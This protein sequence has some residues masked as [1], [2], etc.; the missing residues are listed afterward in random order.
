M[1]QP[2]YHVLNEYQKRKHRKYLLIVS[3]FILMFILAI[4]FTTLGT[5]DTTFSDVAG[6]IFRAFTS[7]GKIFDKQDKIIVLLRLPRMAMAII[8]GIGLSSAGAAMQAATRNPMVS[9]FTI[10]ISNAAAFGASLSI[11]FG[12]G[13]FSGSQLGTVFNAFL[14]ALGCMGL[15]ALISTKVGMSPSTIVL[16]GIA[17]N[18]LFSACTSTIEFFAN[19]HKLAE[20]VQWAFGSLNG[21]QWHEVL[22]VTVIVCICT[23][24]MF[25]HAPALNIIAAGDDE[26]AK[27]LGIHPERVR[28]IVCVEAALATA[29]VISFT[30]VIGFIGLA[31]PHIARIL[32]G[33]DHK[34]MLPFSAVMGALLMLA[35]DTIGRLILAPVMIPVGIVISF[36]GVPIFINLILMQR[37]G[38]V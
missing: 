24:G 3:G 16:T 15:V 35:A 2:A 8:A 26:V 5:T 12:I 27:S 13:F 20:V 17:L 6:S 21:S 31:G 28:L 37:K 22:I 34:Y 32:I 4:F 19:E 36:L 1:K 29:A 9:P 10:G 14:W 25:Y 38:N 11:V 23:V 7:G 30:G 18:Y 33:S